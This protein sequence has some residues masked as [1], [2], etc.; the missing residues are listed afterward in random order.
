M[1]EPT[2]IRRAATG[3]RQAL[4]AVLEELQERAWRIAGEFTRDHDEAE[5]LAQEILIEV[6]RSLPALRDPQ[7]L[8]PWCDTLGRRVCL[9]WRQRERRRQAILGTWSITDERPATAAHPFPGAEEAVLAS[10][11]RDHLRAALRQIGVQ[12]RRALQLFYLEGLSLSEIATHLGIAV[13]AV[14]QRLYWGRQRLREEMETM[15]LT[16]EERRQSA[17]EPVLSFTSWGTFSGMVSQSGPFTATRSLLAQQILCQIAREPKREEELAAAVGADRI[18]VADHLRALA[19]MELVRQDENGRHL[20]DFFILNR[21][22]QEV[23]AACGRE[24]GRHDAQIIAGHVPAIRAAFGRCALPA[25]GFEWEYVRWLLLPVF[26]A[27]LGIRRLHPEVYAIQP[28]L[29]PDG[30]RW[31]F[32]GT[33][34][35][36]RPLEWELCCSTSVDDSLRGVGAF[37]PYPPG[38]ASTVSLP[39]GA[40]RPLLHALANGPKSV[41]QVLAETGSETARDALAGLLESGLASRDGDQLRLAVPVFTLTEEQILHPAIQGACREVVGASRRPGLQGLEVI[42]DGLGFP[43]LKEQYPALRA[44]FAAEVSRYCLEAM[45]EMGLLGKPPIKI[46]GPWGCWVWQGDLALMKR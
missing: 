4:Q 45:V 44:W 29:R 20:A 24:M 19:D 18:Y 41:T 2:L 23:L 3:D 14:K 11:L 17:T 42:L 8:H 30:N 21:Q 46:T 7:C 16:T 25:Q 35:A 13:N 26:V 9:A 22:A 37:S 12:S 28:P 1:L 34:V 43:H 15:P 32:F 31:F 27:N 5:D 38:S 39:D 10:E 36:S 40:Q 33:T 6:C